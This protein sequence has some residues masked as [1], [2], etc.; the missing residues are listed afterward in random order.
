MMQIMQAAAMI[1]IVEIILALVTTMKKPKVVDYCDHVLVMQVIK[2]QLKM[3]LTMTV[4]MAVVMA[5]VM[6]MRMR[7]QT[8]VLVPFLSI[9]E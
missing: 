5:V 2:M 8:A 1:T 3:A 6:V 7:K 4:T 9:V